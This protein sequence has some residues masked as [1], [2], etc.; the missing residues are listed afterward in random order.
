MKTFKIAL[1]F[2][3]TALCSLGVQAQQVDQALNEA[4]GHYQ[5]GDLEE[6]R[7]ALQQAMNELDQ[8]IGQEIL[9]MLPQRMGTLSVLEQDEVIG[10]AAILMVGLHVSRSWGGNDNQQ[11]DL[12]LIA[13]SPLL[14]G[15]NAIL[16][17]PMIGSDPNQKR[18]RISG[19]RGLLQR[20]QGS[21]GNVR[22][23]L[24]VPIG[25]SL[26]SMNFN[27]ITEERTVVEMAN[28]L[29]LERISRMLQ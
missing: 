16:A 24:Q 26:L 1:L 12:Q 11:I 23:D 15:I 17:L 7:F 6:A 22:W 8:A 29:P 14:T 10:S 3:I 13:D 27:G 20:E 25:S 5:R 9:A 28:T 4:R 21:D 2:V 19:Y 18:V